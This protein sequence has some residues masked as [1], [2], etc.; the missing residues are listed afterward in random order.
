MFRQ[1][2][3]TFVY[4]VGWFNISASKSLRVVSSNIL[5]SGIDI[6]S[7][8]RLANII[9]KPEEESGGSGAGYSSSPIL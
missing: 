1:V 6:T 9:N 5:L 8:E 7:G 4:V 2:G 3:S